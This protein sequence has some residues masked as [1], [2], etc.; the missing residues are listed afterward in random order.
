[1]AELIRRFGGE[2]I[3]AP[4]MGE[5]PLDSHDEASVFVDALIDN[6]FDTVVLLTGVGTRMLVGVADAAGK[7]DAFVAALGRVTTVAR[8]PK[9]VAALREVGL[10]PT[11]V[12]PE[13]NTWQDLLKVVDEHASAADKRVAVQE[14]GRSNTDLLDAL[15]HRGADVTPV[16]IY[17]WVLPDDLSPLRD[18]IDRIIAGDVGFALVTSAT[19]VD[20]VFQVAE[21]DGKADDLRGAFKQVGIGAV[22][23]VAAETVRGHG[24]TVDYEPDTPHMTPFVR[25]LARRSVDLLAKKRIAHANGVNTNDWR[26]VDMLWSGAGDAA[27]SKPTIADSV[28]MKACRR[29]PVPYTP[30]W[31]MRQAG[32]YQRAYR[33]IRGSVTIK[34]LC[35]TPDLAAEVTLM[36]VDRLGVDAA[37]IFSDILVVVEPMGFNLEYL[38]GEGPVIDNPVRERGDFDRVREGDARELDY[39]YEALRKTRRA[40]RPDIALIGFCGAPF[41]T[42][43][44][45]VEGGK[46][47]NYRHS[48]TMMFRDPRT[49]E[50]LMDKL[51]TLQIDYMNA[52]VEAGADALQ[53]FDSWAGALGP[54]DYKRFVMPHTKRLI[55]GIKAKHPDTP[56]INFATGNPALL[57]LVKASGGDVIGLDWRVDLADAWASLGHDT[58]VMGNLDPIALH[59]SPNVIRERAKEVLDKAEG[60]PGHI[61]NLGHGILPTVPPEHAAMLVDAVHEMSARNV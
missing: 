57:P 48:K 5:A 23:P 29:E 54:D 10:K 12:V 24:L 8:G 59:A 7:R 16:P 40:L 43:S 13:P 33:E 11:H 47:S 53:V 26:R 30:V 17:R 51:V 1:M 41:T 27:Q 36:A 19:Q 39:V 55:D 6:A 46:S 61:F 15:R 37:I 52:Q 18:A 49:W 56:V 58:P 38:K 25:E 34:E 44:Y 60:R 2:P 4:S 21:Q 22:G 3:S 28:F 14:Y 45:V 20:H 9:P 31:L 42:A 32:R 50:A 35:Y